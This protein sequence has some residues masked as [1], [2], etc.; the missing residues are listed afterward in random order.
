[1]SDKIGK[2]V[3]TMHTHKAMLTFTREEL[4]ILLD[5]LE[6]PIGLAAVDERAATLKARIQY[7]HDALTP[8][9]VRE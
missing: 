8:P 3:Q 7:A 1:V 9:P 4:R 6:L 5:A 2:S